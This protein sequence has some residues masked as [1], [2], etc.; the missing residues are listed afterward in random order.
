VKL[1][2][3]DNALRSSA[4]GRGLVAVVAELTG[5]PLRDRPAERYDA[6][7]R[8]E[9]LWAELDR[10]LTEHGLADQDWTRPCRLRYAG[11]SKSAGRHLVIGSSGAGL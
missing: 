5:G 4:A 7:V 11:G 6:R 10:L 2:V 1:A 3:L 8:R 9:Q